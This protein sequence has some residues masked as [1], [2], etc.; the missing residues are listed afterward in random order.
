MAR[1]DSADRD[2]SWATAEQMLARGDPDFVDE[3]RRIHQP[4]LLADLAPRWFADQRPEA[5]RLLLDYL[6]QPLNAYRHEPLVK[7]LFKLAEKAGDDVVMARFLVLFDRSVRRK[8]KRRRH[9]L[10]N[11]R[12][13]WVA[14]RIAVPRGTTMPRAGDRLPYHY[15]SDP[16]RAN[17]R[18]FTVHTRYYLRRRAWRYFRNLG[19]ADPARYLAG[20]LEA[21]LQ[22]TDDDVPD[23][24]ALLDNWGMVHILFHDCP[25]L[26]AKANGWTLAKGHAL[27]ELAPAPA[28]APRW[29]TAG[30]ALIDLLT[31]ARCRPVRQWSIQMLRR[32]QPDALA[33]LPLPRL[34]PLLG[35]ADPELATLAAEALKQSPAVAALSVEEWLALLDRVNP[36]SLDILCELMVQRLDP[37]AVT[38]AQAVQLAASRPLPVARLGLAWLRGKQPATPEECRAVLGLGEAEAQPTRAELVRWAR[39]ALSAAAD[40]QPTWVLEFLDSRHADVRAEGWAWFL[41]EVRARDDVGLWQKLLESPYDDLRLQL[42]AVLGDRVGRGKEIAIDRARLEPDLLRYLWASVLLNIHRGSRAKPLVVRQMVARLERHPEEA[43]RLL[44]IIAVA[45]RS[46]RGPEWRAGLAGVVQLVERCPDAGPAVRAA[47]PEL[48]MVI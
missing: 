7:R 12:G 41:D 37:A 8:L 26:V 25:A 44:P 31:R 20:V 11:T 40:F 2:G 5:R 42:I 6:D 22:Y 47:F 14:E 38:L 9:A 1:R 48:Q 23:G 28:H 34:L 21:L 10:W 39:T 13:T 46:V 27:A 30:E 4:H 3:L 43:G 35:H 45:L 18:L 17:L 33:R 24:L 29:Q 32:H 15:R 16:G 19:A 36:Q